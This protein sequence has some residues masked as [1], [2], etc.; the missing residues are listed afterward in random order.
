MT[1]PIFLGLLQLC[2][3]VKRAPGRKSVQQT[4]GGWSEGWSLLGAWWIS[5]TWVTWVHI[6]QIFQHWSRAVHKINLT[7][8]LLSHCDI[9]MVWALFKMFC[10]MLFKPCVRWHLWRDFNTGHLAAKQPDE[11]GCTLCMVRGTEG[12]AARSCMSTCKRLLILCIY[13]M[14]GWDN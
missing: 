6:P 8:S 7:C 11:P 9:I 1:S 12:W 4:W 2:F 3:I 5:M 14:H 10:G 13:E